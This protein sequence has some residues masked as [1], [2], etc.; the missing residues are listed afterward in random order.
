MALMLAA[1]LMIDTI[2][3]TSPAR[4]P[5]SRSATTSSTLPSHL[6]ELVDRQH[7]EKQQVQQ[8]VDRDDRER[9]E[10]ERAGH[11]PAGLVDFLGH[12]G[13]GVPSRVGEHHRNQRQ[14]PRP[15]GHRRGA[16]HEVRRRPGAERQAERDEDQQRRHLQPGEQVHHEAARPDATDMDPGHEADRGERD[17]RLTRDRQRN[18]RHRNRRGA[19][20]RRWPRARTVRR[21]TRGRPRWRR[22]RRRSRRQTTSSRSGRPPD[23]RTRRAGTRTRRRP[24]AGARRARHRPSRRQT[25]AGRRRPTCARNSHGF[26]TLAA[27]C[28][29]VNRIPPPITFETMIAAASYGPRRRARVWGSAGGV[30]GRTAVCVCATCCVC[31]VSRQCAGPLVNEAGATS[32]EPYEECRRSAARPTSSSSPWRTR[33]RESL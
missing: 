18:E 16:L 9:A 22:S 23:A 31:L 26:C 15:G 28:G 4:M 33:A 17:D 32:S 25:P 5:S 10:R 8:E 3:M 27:T 2:P 14:Q 21:R 7:V 13:G 12:V 6:R 29:G 20:S 30:E 19:A 1:M 11:V 24:S